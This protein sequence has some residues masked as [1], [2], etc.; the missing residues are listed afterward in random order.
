MTHFRLQPGSKSITRKLKHPFTDS[1]TFSRVI[2]ALVAKNPLG[3]TSYYAIR[4]N[5]PPIMPV[6]ERYTAKFVYLDGTGK[7]VGTSSE[8]Y[9]SIDGYETGIASMITNMANIAAH[10]GKAKH[11][12]EADLFSVTLKCH[13]PS[14]ELYFLSL[15]RDR[16]TVSSYT[17]DAIRRRVEVWAESV[18]ELQ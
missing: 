16:I 17:D 18:P 10:R 3:C 12:K 2:R 7:Q 6:R 8:V 15:A 1:A 4:K 13:D 9:D 5:F 11:K 14:G